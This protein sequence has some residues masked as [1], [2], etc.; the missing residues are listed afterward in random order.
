MNASWPAIEP[1]KKPS[2]TRRSRSSAQ[3]TRYIKSQEFEAKCHRS[4]LGMKLCGLGRTPAAIQLKS[5]ISKAQSFR[6]NQRATWF[7]VMKKLVE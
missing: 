2:K 1:S 3:V 5:L 6:D 4:L 7:E